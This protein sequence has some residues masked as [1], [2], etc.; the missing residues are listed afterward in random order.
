MKENNLSFKEIQKNKG[1]IKKSYNFYNSKDF[2][3]L[4]KNGQN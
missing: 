4:I 2:F 1:L 3:S